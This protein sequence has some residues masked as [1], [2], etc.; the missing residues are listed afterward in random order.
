MKTAYKFRM[1]PNK[2]QEAML[3]LTLETCRYLYNLA[4]ADRKNAYKIEGICRCYEDQ[5]AMLVAEKKEGNYKVCGVDVHK[6][7]LVATILS[8]DGTK[9]TKRFSMAIDGLLR[10]RDWVIGNNCGQVAL[11]STGI[12]WYPIHAVLEEKVDLIVANVYKIKHTPGRK[13]DV[14]DS[15]CIAEL[16]LNGMIEPS[17]M[18]E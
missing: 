2:R 6:K 14:N 11:E 7:F 13:T 1:Y 8:R 15:E 4:L 10:F 5:A 9:D 3:G 17:R 16:C 18:K 12:Y